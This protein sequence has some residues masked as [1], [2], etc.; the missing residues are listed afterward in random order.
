V[1]SVRQ[2]NIIYFTEKEEEFTN[3]LFEI[4][5]KKNSAKVLVFLKKISEATSRTIER[6]TGLHQPDISLAIRY[7]TK[8]GMDYKS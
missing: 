5:I 6:G 2:G 1:L 8:T 7:M 3:L 4:G